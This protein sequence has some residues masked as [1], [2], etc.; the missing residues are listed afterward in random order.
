MA[1]DFNF[2]EAQRSVKAPFYA[3]YLYMSINKMC[4]TKWNKVDWGI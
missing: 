4:T 1:A 2:R 3:K